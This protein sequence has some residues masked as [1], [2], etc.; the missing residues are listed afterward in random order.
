MG[1]A[2]KGKGSSK[3]SSK[4]KH[5]VRKPMMTKSIP[6]WSQNDYN[7][8]RDDSPPPP[9]KGFGKGKDKGKDK[10]KGKGKGKKGKK[11]KKGFKCASLNSHFWEKKVDSEN[12]E[13]VGDEIYS[14]V[15]VKYITKQGW[16]FISPDDPDSLPEVVKSAL[17]DAHEKAKESGKELEEGT[18]NHLYFRKPDVNHEEGFKLATD[19]PCTFQLYVDDKGAGACDV[20]KAD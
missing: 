13:T 14:G 19:T 16:G 6:P 2:A 7:R 11:G 18:E 15:I 5:E 10:G 4:G 17:A 8:Q 9:R 1:K 3:G 12:R 20:S